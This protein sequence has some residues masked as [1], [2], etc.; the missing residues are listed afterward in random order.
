MRPLSWNDGIRTAALLCGAVLMTG[1]VV[2]KKPVSVKELEKKILSE[3]K[4]LKQIDEQIKSLEGEGE[5]LRLSESSLEKTLKD[6]DSTIETSTRKQVRQKIS[7]R[8]MEG[9]VKFLRDQAAV[10]SNE[11]RMWENVAVADL[12][13]YHVKAVF[14]ERIAS[15]P[16]RARVL[17]AALAL[18]IEQIE[19]THSR[20]V[21]L[22]GKEK[23]VSASHEKLVRI[24]TELEDEIK[25]QKKSKSEKRKLYKTTQGRRIIAEQ[26]VRKLKE[27]REELEKLIGKLVEKKKKSLAAQR[28]ENLLKK[29]FQ[30]R[31]GNLPWPVE[32][33]VTASFGRQKHPDLKIIVISNGIKIKTAASQPVKAVAKGTVV[34]ASD[35]RSYGLTVIV[36][37]GGK[38][39]SVYGLLGD[40]SVK[41]SESVAAGSVLGT[42]GDEN[43]PQIYFEFKNQ[44]QS[45]NPLLWLVSR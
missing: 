17:G 32:G 42:V 1:N 20:R 19:D 38:N 2:A 26:E 6:L 18:R 10:L 45:E 33:E 21:V 41:E 8:E 30:E 34:Y 28:E 3:K 37:H 35:F 43:P 11:G 40:I 36:D 5:Q 44:G 24:K 23:D 12:N 4:D 29:S 31:R 22:K 25:S 9:R 16:M 39:F 27:T 15:Y 13:V 7:I 14:P